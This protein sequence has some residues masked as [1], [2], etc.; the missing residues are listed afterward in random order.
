MAIGS[1]EKIKKYTPTDTTAAAVAITIGS[2]LFSGLSLLFR[3][4]EPIPIPA[5]AA[6]VIAKMIISLSISQKKC[7]L[8]K[9]VG[10]QQ[11]AR[12]YSSRSACW[13]TYA[14]TVTSIANAEKTKDAIALTVSLFVSRIGLFKNKMILQLIYFIQ[15]LA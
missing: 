8:Q 13:N 4:S 1:S 2:P 15:Q 7:V 11:L 6:L 3:K 5:N 10:S 14:A 12:K 9:T